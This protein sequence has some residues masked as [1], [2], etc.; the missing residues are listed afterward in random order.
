MTGGIGQKIP[1]GHA[2]LQQILQHK[3]VFNKGVENHVKNLF[4]LLIQLTIFQ[5]DFS[6]I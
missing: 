6:I 5:H 4:A 1:E 3:M 2:N